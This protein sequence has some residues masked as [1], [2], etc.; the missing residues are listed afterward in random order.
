MRTRDS[1]L[2]ELGAGL[3][4][5]G[6]VATRAATEQRERENI[7]SVFRAET[8]VRDEYLQFEQAARERRG[9]NAL[10]V[11]DEAAKWWEERL[12][13]AQ[14]DLVNPEQQSTF[15][16][17]MTPVRQQ[18][19][20][21]VSRHEADER[22]VSL[23]ESAQAS[24][25][26]SIDLAAAHSDDPAALIE[27]KVEIRRR[28]AV[29]AQLN[30]YTPER[31]E[32]EERVVLTRLHTQVINEIADL[33][34]EFA[35]AYLAANR[36]EINGPERVALEKL[37][38][39]ST[40]VAQ[41]QNATD[42]LMAAGMSRA[43]TLAEARKR[44]SGAEEDEVVRRLNAR[45]SE[46]DAA[47]AAGERQTADQAW[48]LFARGGLTS[49]P[50][51]TLARL[52][53]RTLQALKRE[54]QRRAA[55]ADIITNPDRYA[56]LRTMAATDPNAFRAL[57]L[58]QEF[59]QL[60]EAE[61]RA[62]LSMQIQLKKPDTSM[63]VASLERQLGNAKDLAKITDKAKQGQFDTAVTNQ[64]QAEAKAA[65]RQLNYEER[66]RVID[67]MLIEN[68]EWGRN[69]RLY[70]LP[71]GSD[72][73]PVIPDDERRAIERALRSRGKAVTDAEVMRVFK[74]ANGF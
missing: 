24:I 42:T 29:V 69:R 17:L 10:G 23:V 59:G 40:T 65:G 55:G 58:R 63:D 54:E 19:M 22:R 66:Q 68:D 38:S 34:P 32:F 25:A 30:G 21:A 74:I 9:Q 73:N 26:T 18:A 51:S 3:M 13:K 70:Q 48:D 47:R 71:A 14:K 36:D 67:R 4:T 50:P 57:D 44:Y 1:G 49:I 35:Q 7:E 53:G 8:A 56:E 60:A 12:K 15:D 39:T 6:A 16:R 37:V 43:Q 33:E 2:Q 64:I 52:D 41:A 28:L 46:L 72:I 45:F 31:R 62:L 5:V 20:Q 11:T 61:R 27:G